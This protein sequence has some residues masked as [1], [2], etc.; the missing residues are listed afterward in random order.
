MRTVRKE[1]HIKYAQ[2]HR[3]SRCVF[4]NGA[5]LRLFTVFSLCSHF[6]SAK[7][8][9]MIDLCFLKIAADVMKVKLTAADIQTVT[10]SI[11]EHLVYNFPY[12][13]HTYF[14]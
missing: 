9:D 6:V 1:R 2:E 13:Q 3:M 8:N 7:T 14:V 11:T 10:V 5:L 4:V 12:L